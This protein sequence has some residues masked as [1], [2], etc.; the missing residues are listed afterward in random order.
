MLTV[1]AEAVIEIAA[2]V[3]GIGGVA[4]IVY[5]LALVWREHSDEVA[6]LDDYRRERLLRDTGRTS[7]VFTPEDGRAALSSPSPA[8]PLSH[9][10]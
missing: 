7:R 3:S 10:S 6:Y 5:F 2:F 1:I 8:L 9:H 4:F